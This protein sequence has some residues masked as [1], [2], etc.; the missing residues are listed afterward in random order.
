MRNEGDIEMAIEITKNIILTIFIMNIIAHNDAL[1]T[2]CVA[3]STIR[4]SN[5]RHHLIY[6][7]VNKL[8]F[9][10]SVSVGAVQS[11]IIGLTFKKF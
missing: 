9:Y 2:I 4:I 7:D 8:F 11:P 5:S 10:C 6:S 1:P 3:Y